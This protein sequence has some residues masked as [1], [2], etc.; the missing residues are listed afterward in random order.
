MCHD[1]G[2]LQVS[3]IDGVP[4]NRVGI[5][6]VERTEVSG[7]RRVKDADE[8][9]AGRGV[10]ALTVLAC[11][12]VLAGNWLVAGQHVRQQAHVGRAVCVHVVAQQG[13]LRVGQ[14]QAKLDQL[15]QIVAAQLRS[16]ED[17]QRLFGFE[18]IAELTETFTVM[19]C[20]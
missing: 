14:R 3:R 6:D 10:E 12:A 15:A 17:Q 1:E 8:V 11:K 2:V 4:R 20:R 7:I 16:Y 18:R 19:G 13:K 5:H 9:Q